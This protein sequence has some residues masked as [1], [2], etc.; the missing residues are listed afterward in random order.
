MCTTEAF[1]CACYELIHA[2]KRKLSIVS[3][4]E[5]QDPHFLCWFDVLG[6]RDN[7]KSAGYL[8]SRPKEIKSHLDRSCNLPHQPYVQR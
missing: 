6:E 4:D 3:R 5:E 8:Q 7:V 1:G 2:G